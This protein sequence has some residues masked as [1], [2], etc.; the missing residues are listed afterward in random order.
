MPTNEAQQIN[1]TDCNLKQRGKWQMLKETKGSE[2]GGREEEG[3]RGTRGR[4]RRGR[5]WMVEERGGRKETGT[6]ERQWG[7][8]G[9]GERRGSEHSPLL[10]GKRRRK[11]WFN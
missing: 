3:D 8:E 6:G 2:E 7:W 4:E 10:G 1:T 9:G 11:R 5:Q